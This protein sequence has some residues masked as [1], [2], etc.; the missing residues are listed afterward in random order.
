VYIEENHLMPISIPSFADLLEHTPKK[1]IRRIILK[2]YPEEED[3]RQLL[4][5]CAN[6]N[7]LEGC[8]FLVEEMSV[9]PD[10]WDTTFFADIYV[11]SREYYSVAIY[12]VLKGADW[13]KIHVFDETDFA[14][15][16]RDEFIKFLQLLSV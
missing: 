8:K 2:E 1:E 7:F 13:T 5:M 9:S 11:L 15:K 16:T 6:S 14:F 3:R 12:L 10:I 4:V